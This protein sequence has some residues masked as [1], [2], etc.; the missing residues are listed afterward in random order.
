MELGEL[1]EALEIKLANIPAS[2]SEA[3]AEAVA[4]PSSPDAV[5]DISPPDDGSLGAKIEKH[6]E[7][8][9]QKM[10]KQGQAFAKMQA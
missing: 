9:K 4:D 3:K 10:L 6:I 5:A 1:K 7:E 2:G 8:T